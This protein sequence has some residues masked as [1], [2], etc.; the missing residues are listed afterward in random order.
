MKFGEGQVFLLE[1]PAFPSL[2]PA[3]ETGPRRAGSVFPSGQT[4]GHEALEQAAPTVF[5][6]CPQ[7]RLA[8]R[9]NTATVYPN[10]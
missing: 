3:P 6:L 7:P 2:P 1:P 4:G 10:Y 9:I 8:V 5:L